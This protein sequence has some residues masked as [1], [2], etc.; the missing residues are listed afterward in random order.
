MVTEAAQARQRVQPRP[1][2]ES[3][4][5]G[6]AGGRTGT[7]KEFVNALTRVLGM[8]PADA[9]LVRLVTSGI[10]RFWGGRGV[11]MIV[12]W[13]DSGDAASGATGS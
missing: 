4:C 10:S 1:H 6:E 8:E 3:P 7:D 13:Q 5:C 11:A 12:G 2:A 9:V